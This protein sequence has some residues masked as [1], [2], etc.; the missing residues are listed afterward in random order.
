MNP[1]LDP[2]QEIGARR[3]VG[4]EGDVVRKTTTITVVVPVYNSQQSLRM[5]I[6]RLEPVL[7]SI[8]TQYE[9]LLVNDASRD[10][11]W[12]VIQDICASRLWVHGIDLMRNY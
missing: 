2:E 3:T 12:K 11:S 1:T 9:V 6:E 8:A 4:K 10:G 7:Q 5:L